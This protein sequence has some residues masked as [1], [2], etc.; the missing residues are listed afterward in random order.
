MSGGFWGLL[1]VA[2][3][4]SAG[5]GTCAG[6]AFD[7]S[8]LLP[9]AEWETGKLKVDGTLFLK[10]NDFVEGSIEGLGV[11]KNRMVAEGRH[12]NVRGM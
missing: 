12:H 9:E 4:A 2:A 1:G 6:T 10:D 8:R 11:L 3:G 5:A 7:S